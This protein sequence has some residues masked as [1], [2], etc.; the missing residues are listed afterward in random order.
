MG[1]AVGGGPGTG[2][3]EAG[4]GLFALAVT[5]VVLAV[6][7][8]LIVKAI[9]S[10]PKVNVGSG[11]TAPAG[12][13]T[14]T[15][16]PGGPAVGGAAKNAG[17]DSSLTV[18]GNE[19]STT[20]DEVAKG[21]LTS[22]LSVI[23]QAEITAGG[24]G[25]VTAASLTSGGGGS[26]TAAPSTGPSVLSVASAGGASGGVTLAARSA[27]GTCWYLWTSASGTWYGAETGLTS[28][29]P[30]PLAGAPAASAVKSGTI[31]WQQGTF[32]AS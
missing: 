10:A 2:R 26:F 31:G 32:P 7:A 17:G 9:P 1:D 25:D 30:P 11:T 29:A 24:Y 21:N 3:D 12:G 28:C 16:A 6:V 18:N 19:L 27:S 4:V 22:A 5:L 15:L 23:Q 14:A 8:V 13:A 20:G